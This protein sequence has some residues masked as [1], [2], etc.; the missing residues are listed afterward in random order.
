MAHS[1][2]CAEQNNAG[3]QGKGGGKILAGPADNWSPVFSVNVFGAVNIIKAFV[4]GMISAG[5]LSSGLKSYVVTTSSVVG[6]LNHNIG[7]YSV[8]KMAATAVC[9]QFA[10]ELE[11]MGPSAA[12]ISPHSL[13][14]TVAATGFLTARD[15]DGSKSDASGALVKL[16][17]DGGMH[18]Q[19]IVDG[20]FAG[21][22]ADKYYI[23]VDD[24]QDIPTAEQLAVRVGDQINGRRPSRA[25]QLGQLLKLLDPTAYAQRMERQK[26]ARM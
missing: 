24:V 12:H 14:P 4:P 5:P 13:H 23:I 3:I 9:E 8:S 11:E 26:V 10:I 25:Q 20:L 17:G 18:A 22:D 21:L 7:P 15:S 19:D 2:H 6:L 16:V 1:S